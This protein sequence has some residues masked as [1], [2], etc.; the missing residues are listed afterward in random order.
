M[1]NNILSYIF[2]YKEIYF[3]VPVIIYIIGFL[4]LQGSFSALNG[5]TLMSDIAFPVY[6]FNFKVYLYKGLFV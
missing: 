3:I 2:K 6:P 5:D 4:C 1:T